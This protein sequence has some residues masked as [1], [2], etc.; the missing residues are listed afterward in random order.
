VKITE[1]AAA[2]I[3]KPDG[4]FLLGQR[5]PDTFYAGYW[6]FPGGKVEAGET[7]R[8]ALIRE[9]REEL[10][11]EVTQATPWIVREHVYAHAHVRLH[12][13]RVTGWRG[14]IRDHVHTALAWQQPDNVN[15]T[16]MLPANAP[17]LAA[18]TL[19][20]I[21]GITHAHEIGVPS[22][23][24]L[25]ERELANGLRLAQLREAKLPADQRE[26]FAAAAAALC[27]KHHARLLVNGDAALAQT[28]GADGLHL[29]SSQL[30]NLNAKP[31]FPLVAASCHDAAELKQ[32]AQLQL[33]F[34][35]LGAVKPTASHP[36]Q[37]GMGWP[38]VAAL[39]ENYPLPVYAIGGLSRADLAEARLIGAQGIAAIRALWG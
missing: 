19:P 5:A 30:K 10:A 26:T 3:E 16:P 22:Q 24:A 23:L 35:V 1:V 8:A 4:S 7:P 25:L 39:L 14:E 6:E 27:R 38:A 28:I 17:V 34:V 13:F 31:S 36:G 33:D 21:Y 9:L 2:V 20:D 29:T 15:V 37:S 32:A 11:I 12:F 18:L